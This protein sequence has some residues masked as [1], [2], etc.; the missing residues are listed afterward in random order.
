MA[1]VRGDRAKSYNVLVDTNIPFPSMYDLT[2][3]I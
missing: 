2:C 1:L 3:L